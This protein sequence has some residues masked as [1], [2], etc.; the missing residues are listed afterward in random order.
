MIFIAHRGLTQGPD[1]ELENKPEQIKKSLEA[2][3]DCEVDVWWQDNRWFLGHD[4][5]TYQVNYEFVRQPKLWI[6]AKNLNA[7]YVLTADPVLNFFWHQN[8]DV[9]LTSQGDIWTYP[10]KDLTPSSIQLMPEWN[11]PNFEYLE[12]RCLGI[13]SDYVELIKEIYSQRPKFEK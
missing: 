4:K 6:H 9:A 10:G 3:F 8:D 1:P 12:F 5:P 13:C 11:D 7:L 2:G